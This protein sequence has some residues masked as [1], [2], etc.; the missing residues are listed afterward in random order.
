MNS[1]EFIDA[2]RERH[3]LTS[4]NKLA[5]YLDIDRGR[6][7]MYR[8]RA[9]KLDPIAC[10]KVAEALDESPE[11][12][13]AC[14]Q[15]ERAKRTED[16]VVWQRLAQLAKKSAAAAILL[17]LMVGGMSAPQPAQGASI[18]LND[19]YIIRIRRWLR[20]RLRPFWLLA[21]QPA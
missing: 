15:A 7:S 12:V 10:H 21:S 5:A 6:I 16:R 20:R 14:I 19:L 13:M 1:V 3:G 8:R 9:R 4:D 2:V 18:Y 11:F 17:A